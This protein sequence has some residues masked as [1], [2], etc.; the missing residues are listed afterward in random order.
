MFVP[1][2]LKTEEKSKAVQKNK[3]E[4]VQVGDTFSRN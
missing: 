4:G 2:L 3:T 1:T